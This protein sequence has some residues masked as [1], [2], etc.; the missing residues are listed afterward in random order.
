MSDGT[1]TN[2]DCCPECGSNWAGSS[3]CPSCGF[4]PAIDNRN[5]QPL[6]Q[7]EVVYEHWWEVVPGWLWSLIV[8]V[9]MIVVLSGCV[10]LMFASSTIRMWWTI[11]QML[12]GLVG[13]G[14]VHF[15]AYL[16]S[17]SRSD[18]L[19]PLDMFLQPLRTWQPVF[20]NLPDTSNLLCWCA[21]SGTAILSGYFVVDGINYAAIVEQEAIAR[22]RQRLEEEAQEET[23][24]KRNGM[25]LVVATAVAEQAGG[26]SQ[27]SDTMTGALG[28]FTGNTEQSGILNAASD[29]ESGVEPALEQGRIGAEGF[30]FVN[31]GTEEVPESISR[32]SLPRTHSGGAN[33]GA[34]SSAGQSN[35]GTAQRHGPGRGPEAAD[36]ITQVECLILGY[37][38]NATGEIR[39]LLL[40]AAPDRRF[41]RF[42]AKVPVD[43]VAPE[44]V[45]LLI[46]KFEEI[47]A[48]RPMVR[49]PYGG[50][51][52]QPEL[53]CVA[54]YDS[55]TADG[56][57]HNAEVVQ[58]MNIHGP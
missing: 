50:R 27:Q 13:L 42:V 43:K 9:C 15:M 51:W 3:W 10:R 44:V 32:E 48:R 40:A 14:T 1:P 28:D 31:T 20:H 54:T 23:E 46:R 45:Q 6:Q 41:L 26:G 24:G 19:G 21:F 22:Q 7:E 30:N 18:Q 49:C 56:R 34:G 36:D 35:R 11:A 12:G 53:F 4:Y 29:P 52:L 39:S 5:D 37:T 2:T 17:V 57:L 25:Q 8:G 38:T 47:P 55:W 33:S 16:Y 58:M